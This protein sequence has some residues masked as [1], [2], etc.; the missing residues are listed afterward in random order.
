MLLMVGYMMGCLMGGGVGFVQQ[1]LFFLKNLVSL[2]YGKY[3]DVMGKNYGVVQS[4]CIMIVLKMVMVLKL[5][6]I[7]IVIC[8]GFGE[9]VV[10]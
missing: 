3:I 6:I 1:L 2:V 7:I 4:G 10:K 9:F 8:G 5:V